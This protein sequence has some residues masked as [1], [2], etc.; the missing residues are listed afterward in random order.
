M[1][2]KVYVV[3]TGKTSFESGA[4]S[5]GL[6]E[7]DRGATEEFIVANS[8]N[9]DAFKANDIA[10]KNSV[11]I[12]SSSVTRQAMVDIVNQDDGTGGESDSNNR[13]YGWN[14]NW[15]WICKRATSRSS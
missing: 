3:K 11:E 14:N 10:Y 15:R 6:S 4:P 1:I 7:I 9:K 8:G 13:E 5:A 2:K 12:E